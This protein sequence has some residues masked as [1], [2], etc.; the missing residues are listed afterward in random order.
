[1]DYIVVE[2]ISCDAYLGV[3]SKERK[4]R[5]HVRVD[6]R[7]GVELDAAANTDNLELTVDYHQL[8][9]RIQKTAADHECRLV[10]SLA[11][12]L[13]SSVLTDPRV[14]EASVR[15]YK[16]PEDLQ[17]DINHV[18]VEVTRRNG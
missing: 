3:S 6:V 8:V 13:C 2:G 10:E 11:S 14:R 9:Q 5:Q 1:M 15:V 7:V 12:H 17:D 16:F 4:Q 18:S